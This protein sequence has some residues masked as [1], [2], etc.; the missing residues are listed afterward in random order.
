LLELFPKGR[1]YYQRI[2]RYAIY[3]AGTGYSLLRATTG[4]FFAALLDGMIPEMRVRRIL[5]A[6][7]INAAG[8]GRKAFRLLIPVR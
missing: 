1:V 4:S 6:I 5:M 7:K 3:K 2:R 8:S